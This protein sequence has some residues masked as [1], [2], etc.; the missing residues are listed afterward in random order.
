MKRYYYFIALYDNLSKKMYNYE[1]KL[2]RKITSINDLKEIT[3]RLNVGKHNFVVINYKIID[4]I[5]ESKNDK[6]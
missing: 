4:V 1:V 6:R 3:T 5:K 2:D